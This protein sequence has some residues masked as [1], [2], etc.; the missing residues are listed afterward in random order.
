MTD[1]QLNAVVS[2][3][4]TL[5]GALVGAAV[6]YLVGRQQ[7]RATV[8]STNRQAWINALRDTLAEFQA[9]VA[10]LLTSIEMK[11]LD[12]SEAKV[13]MERVAQLKFKAFLLVN[14]SEPQHLELAKRMDE[15][16]ELSNSANSEGRLEK[17]R[18]ANKQIVQ[19]AQAVIKTEWERVKLG[20]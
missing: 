20:S 1:I 6:S 15:I 3:V 8:I 4:S 9:C 11:Q 16:V 10:T 14:P 2:L 7:F 12:V 19:L 18:A 13:R 17:C 5:G